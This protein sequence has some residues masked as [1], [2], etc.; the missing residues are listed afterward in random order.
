MEDWHNHKAVEALEQKRK[1]ALQHYQRINLISLLILV[2]F[3]GMGSYQF[4]FKI[5]HWWPL[6]LMGILG[7]GLVWSSW[8]SRQQYHGYLQF[9]QADYLP[10]LIPIID[11]ALQYQQGS[12]FPQAWIPGLKAENQ[13][14][15]L[16]NQQ[17]YIS[18]RQGQVQYHL[19]ALQINEWQGKRRKRSKIRFQGLLLRIEGLSDW[20]SIITAPALQPVLKDLGVQ[21]GYAA[22]LRSASDGALLLYLYSDQVFLDGR[23]NEHIHQSQLP[24]KLAQELRSILVFV[25]TLAQ[26]NQP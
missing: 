21:W 6:L 7:L 12:A 1:Q 16:K 17:H 10:Q 11:P 26:L 22:E 13:Q 19:I 8:Q 24:K 25:D 2:L 15:E 3:L 9:W 23:P 14:L 5:E 20:A 4:F 18:G